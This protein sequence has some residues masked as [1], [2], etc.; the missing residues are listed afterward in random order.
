M[1]VT[2]FFCPGGSFCGVSK[3]LWGIVACAFRVLV[4]SSVPYTFFAET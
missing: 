3:I 2:E 1:I 4:H